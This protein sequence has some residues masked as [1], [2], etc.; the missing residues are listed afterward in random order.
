MA[1]STQSFS[2]P[3]VAASSGSDGLVQFVPGEDMIAAHR[4]HTNVRDRG[5]QQQIDKPLVSFFGSDKPPSAMPSSDTG[6]SA[7]VAKSKNFDAADYLLP[8]KTTKD[9]TESEGET[10]HDTASAFQSRFQKLFAGAPPLPP[11]HDS[12]STAQQLSPYAYAPTEDR[13]SRSDA[14]DDRPSEQQVDGHMARLMGLLSTK[15]CA[16]DLPIRASLIS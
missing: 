16:L 10:A 5:S 9:D 13:M 1:D 2:D 12:P 6:K 14:L 15:V 3:A 7:S 11:L 8:S 4:R